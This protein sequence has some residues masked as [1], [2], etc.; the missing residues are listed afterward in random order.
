MLSLK[1][2]LTL[3]NNNFSACIKLADLLVTLSEGQRAA[4]YYKHALKIEPNSIAGH[5]GMGKAI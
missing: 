3:D 5:F 4:K 2:C 1:K